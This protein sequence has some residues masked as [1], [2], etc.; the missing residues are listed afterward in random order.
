MQES[1]Y[2]DL[3]RGDIVAARAIKK[4]RAPTAEE[5]K[6]TLFMAVTELEGELQIDVINFLRCETHVDMNARYEN[7]ETILHVAAKRKKIGA[8]VFLI[9]AGASPKP[10]DKEGIEPYHYFNSEEAK[11]VNRLVLTFNQ[12]LRNSLSPEARV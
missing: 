8:F 4:R 1:F 6:R 11:E 3:K 12:T 2:E 9:F 5:L 10:L 7:Q